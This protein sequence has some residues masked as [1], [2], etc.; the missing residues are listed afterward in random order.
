MIDTTDRG[1]QTGKRRYESRTRADAARIT[2]R[3]HHGER[4][5]VYVCPYCRGWHLGH[6]SSQR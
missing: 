1:C 4:M 6:G 3:R 5:H 2:I